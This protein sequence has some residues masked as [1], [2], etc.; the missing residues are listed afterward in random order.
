[1]SSAYRKPHTCWQRHTSLSH[2]FLESPMLS[3]ATSRSERERA[4]ETMLA[5]ASS[6]PG[7]VT[8]SCRP[9]ASSRSS[10]SSSGSDRCRRVQTTG[11]G[12]HLLYATPLELG[13]ST[14][15]LG[16]PAGVDLRTGR[17]GYIV[18]A[19]SRHPSGRRY[20]WLDPD[21]TVFASFVGTPDATLRT[22]A[23]GL[24]VGVL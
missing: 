21:A 16:R 6:S 10:G 11:K 22:N 24:G 13:N 1:M 4:A 20:A 5:A 7:R 9:P 3:T 14:A 8:L 12:R 18:A 15:R 17:R 19:P 2:G 23:F